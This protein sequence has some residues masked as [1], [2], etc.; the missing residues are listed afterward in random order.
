[1]GWHVFRSL[2]GLVLLIGFCCLLSE[3]KKA[4]NWRLVP[5]GVLL[6]IILAALVLWVPPIESALEGVSI[7]FIRLL[8]FSNEGSRF[9]FGKLASDTS[10]EA[11]IAFKVLPS[12]I[13]ISAFTSVLYYLGLLQ[14][15]VYGFAWIMQ[16]TMHLSGAESF[17]AAANIFIGQTEAPLMVKPYLKDMTRSEI[18]C[19]MTGGMATI[20]GGVFVAYISILGG[21]DPQRQVMIGKHLLT[22]S[23]LSAPAAILCAKLLLPETE[24]IDHELKVS[25]EKIGCNLFDAAASG[26]TQGL[27]LALNVGAILLV[28]IAMI[29]MINYI[30]L[31]WIGSWT[32]LNTV[33]IEF[34]D[35]RFE[36]L[37]LQFIFGLL[38]APVAWIIGIESGNLLLIGQLLGEKMVL[39]EFIAF[40]SLDKMVDGEILTNERTVMIATY[41]LCGFANFGSIGIQIGG[42][43]VLAPNQRSNLA[44]LALRAMIGGMVACLMTACVAGMFLH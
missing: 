15:I 31:N 6:Q 36:G 2:L 30:T 14:K 27:K 18:L 26:T 5:A 7:F 41:A 37:N 16:R 39:N 35:G 34:T 40:I 42:I 3:K 12:I 32:G 10:Y 9:I 43:A 21:D 8:E 24:A 23:I 22:A 38:F 1:M 17:A 33:I 25:R 4:I 29:A 44:T 11:V 19:L 13:F 20:A 28:F